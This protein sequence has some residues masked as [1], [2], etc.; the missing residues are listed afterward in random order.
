VT[1]TSNG[2]GGT[3]ALN[4]FYETVTGAPVSVGTTTYDLATGQTSQTV[5]PPGED[6]SQYT[7]YTA[8]GVTI[9]STPAASPDSTATDT[10]DPDTSDCIEPAAAL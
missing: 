9:S 8:W 2:Q 3:L 4:W 7:D 6:F 1:V 5:T 10:L